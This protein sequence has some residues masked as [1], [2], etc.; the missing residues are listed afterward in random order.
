MSGTPGPHSDNPCLGSVCLK[1]TPNLA[2]P[3]KDYIE[4]THRH[5]C[6]CAL[7]PR[8]CESGSSLLV[9]LEVRETA[10]AI[11]VTVWVNRFSK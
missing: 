4:H 8:F 7:L 2:G 5:L 1:I 6:T 9:P 3:G 11:V 10:A